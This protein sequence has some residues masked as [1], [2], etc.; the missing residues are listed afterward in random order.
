VK[1]AVEKYQETESIWEAAEAG[2]NDA[3]LNAVGRHLM[4][5]PVLENPLR[6][7]NLQN[8]K[9]RKQKHQRLNI[10]SAK[11]KKEGLVGIV[12]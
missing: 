2:V 5:A 8:Q 9:R 7:L 10:F 3:I 1:A 12:I 6:N 11:E 4:K